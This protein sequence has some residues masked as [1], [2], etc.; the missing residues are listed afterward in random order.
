MNPFLAL[1]DNI[2]KS[3]PLIE[4]NSDNPVSALYTEL[5]KTI[6]NKNLQIMLYG[7]Y[8]A[9][10]STLVNTLLGRYEAKENDIPTTDSVDV[11]NWGGFHLLDTPGVNAPI[12]HENITQEQVK[13]SAAMLFVIR[14]GD[15][16]AKDVY[17]RLFSMLK[18]DKKVFIV[19]NHQLS[20]ADDKIRAVKKINEI[21]STLA[22]DYNVSNE[23]IGK[24][25]IFPMNVRTAYN[26]RLKAHEKLLEHSG[27][28]GFI[29]AF[30]QWTILQDKEQSHLD[31]FKNQINDRWYKPVIEKLDKQVNKGESKELRALRDDRLMLESEKRSI[32]TSATHFVNQQVN[33]LK[34]DV[35]GIVSNSSSELEIDTKLEQVFMPLTDNIEVWLGDELSGVS[36]KLTVTIDKNAKLSKTPSSSS[37]AN[38]A[39]AKRV[40]ELL[41]DKKNIE[42]GLF[43]LRKLKF[44]GVKG[45]HGTT[46]NKLA[47]KAA[48]AIQIAIFLYDLYKADSDQDKENSQN[49]QRSMELY[50]CVDQICSTVIG[51]LT[52]SVHDMVDFTFDNQ[53]NVIQQ[54]LDDDCQVSDNKNSS[55]KKLT[56]LKNDMLSISF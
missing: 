8:N 42:K 55:Y 1:A 27:Y 7:A 48:P 29:N 37:S 46:I 43:L 50:Q 45:R 40:K 47:G 6:E 51:D 16:D 34:S 28:N 39:I 22:P 30:K 4:Q 36:E 24:I 41:S 9:G 44:P 2:N 20:N 21:I 12:E 49:R 5:N 38:D 19:L 23:K 17:E 33:L 3:L 53:I 11:Y 56:E 54:Q 35:S 14:E 15:Q 26:G 52:K 13:R 32:K 10:K 18:Q 25:S 31:S